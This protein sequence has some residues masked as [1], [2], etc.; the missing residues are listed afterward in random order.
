VTGRQATRRYS[1][2]SGSAEPLC[3]CLIQSDPLPAERVTSR[4]NALWITLSFISVRLMA[5]K[6]R[7]LLLP[8]RAGHRGAEPSRGTA[9]HARQNHI[10]TRNSESVDLILSGACDSRNA[11][12]PTAA[13]SWGCPG[14]RHIS[15]QSQGGGGW[16]ATPLEACNR[17]TPQGAEVSFCRQE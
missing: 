10:T 2:R 4:L 16:G 6:P 7:L 12:L 11:P 3:F 14:I 9:Y 17:A 1:T 15:G 13:D 5:P 8:C